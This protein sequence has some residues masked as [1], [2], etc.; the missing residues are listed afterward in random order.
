M[1]PENQ[2]V[3]ALNEEGV[4]HV[5][6][7]VGLRNVERCKVIILRVNLWT[8]V[9]RK[10]VVAEFLEQ[11]VSHERNGVQATG[12]VVVADWQGDVNRLLESRL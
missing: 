7:R 11:P 10:T 5:A 8:I 9:D 12:G 6:R 3:F 2:V 1:S 4:L